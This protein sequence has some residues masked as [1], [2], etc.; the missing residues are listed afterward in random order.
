MDPLTK[1]YPFYTP[2][3]YASDNPILNIDLD[4]LEGKIKVLA[5]DISDGLPEIRTQDGGL[6]RFLLENGNNGM[7]KPLKGAAI[8]VALKKLQKGNLMAA[9]GRKFNTSRMFEYDIYDID[10]TKYKNVERGVNFGTKKT[11]TKGINQL[12]A[13]SRKSLAGR[14][15]GLSKFVGVVFQGLPA[16]EALIKN[17]IGKLNP[18]GFV[19]DDM[20]LDFEAIGLGV[21]DKLVDNALHKGSDALRDLFNGNKSVR[22]NF[23]LEGASFQTLQGIFTGEITDFDQFFESN[24]NANTHDVDLLFKKDTDQNL[25][26]KSVLIRNQND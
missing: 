12:Q 17:D 18:I 5:S 7:Q 4:G 6:V 25:Q 20:I 3:Q 15:L 14:L 24:S 9:D 21:T 11:T 1:E 22:E 16:A 13:F 2:Y 8:N 10:G 26:L 23:L 19:V